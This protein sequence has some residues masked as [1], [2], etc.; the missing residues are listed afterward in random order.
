MTPEDLREAMESDEELE[1]HVTGRETDTHKLSPQPGWHPC[2]IYWFHPNGN[3]EIGFTTP[4]LDEVGVT[5]LKTN[6]AIAFRRK[7]TVHAC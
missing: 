4:E 7:E 5:V 6:I 2:F 1:Y 3:V